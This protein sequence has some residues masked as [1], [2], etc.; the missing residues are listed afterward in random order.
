MIFFF[1]EDVSKFIKEKIKLNGYRFIFE[2]GDVPWI[3][4]IGL[5]LFAMTVKAA[6][7]KEKKIC[8]INPHENIVQLFKLSNLLDFVQICGSKKD[9]LDYFS[10]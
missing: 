4:S 7:M 10:H 3:D 5:G 6:M 8:I 9:A 2:L 1:L